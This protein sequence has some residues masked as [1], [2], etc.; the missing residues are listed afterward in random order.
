MPTVLTYGHGDVLAGHDHQWRDDLSPW[1]LT[2]EG[3]GWYGRGAVDNK[4]QHSINL[5][6]LEHVIQARQGRLGFKLTMILETG[7]ERG[8]VGVR[9]VI[10]DLG[11]GQYILGQALSEHGSESG[12]S[13]GE[14]LFGWNTLE[15]LA[16]GA[17]NPQKP[18]N[19]VPPRAKAFCD[20]RIVMDCITPATRLDLSSPWVGVV[21][22]AIRK[23]TPQ[24]IALIPNLAGTVPNDIF[25]DMPGLPTIG[26]PHS[27]KN[28]RTFVATPVVG[29][30]AGQCSRIK[31]MLFAATVYA[32]VIFPFFMW[33]NAVATQT[34]LI[35]VVALM[36]LLKSGP[37]TVSQ[38]S[39]FF[40]G[41]VLSLAVSIRSI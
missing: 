28:I 41:D 29:Y 13:Y 40:Y 24:K 7:E 8:S 34:A 39:G 20:L 38:D 25:A 12:L 11:I 3:E 35:V 37:D 32:I 10:A 17:G 30:M 1:S 9:A 27:P 22:D 31:I 15:I 36:A 14:R 2:V 33:L 19:A 5:A 26:V 18:V 6:A 16:L 4:G 23:V 21:K